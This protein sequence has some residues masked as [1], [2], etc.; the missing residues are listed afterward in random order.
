MTKNPKDKLWI[1]KSIDFK[2]RVCIMLPIHG[3][4]EKVSDLVSDRQKVWYQKF[5]IFDGLSEFCFWMRFK[6][7]ERI[8]FVRNFAVS[9]NGNGEWQALSEAA[10]RK[11]ASPQQSL[12]ASFRFAFGLRA[13]WHGE[14]TNRTGRPGR[15]KK[16]C[17]GLA[18]A[19]EFVNACV[20]R[21]TCTFIHFKNNKKL[22]NRQQFKSVLTTV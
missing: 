5:L 3:V 8:F 9:T 15:G 11:A 12:K 4:S 1:R 18:L 7:L 22:W 6:R 16:V 13:L 10:P 20:R 14:T 19:R 21:R 2:Y 17:W